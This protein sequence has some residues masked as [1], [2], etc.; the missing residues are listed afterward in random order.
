MM[1]LRSLLFVPGNRADMLSKAAG[2]SPDAF[3]PDMEDSVPAAE[4]R[5]CQGDGC[6]APSPP[7]RN[8]GRRDTAG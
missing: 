4:K 3:I 6:G 1:L 7:G 5:C 2:L 8:G